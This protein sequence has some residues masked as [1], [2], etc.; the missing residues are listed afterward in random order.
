MV[1]LLINV[2]RHFEAFLRGFPAAIAVDEPPAAADVYA[3]V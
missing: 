1:N 2:E 3:V